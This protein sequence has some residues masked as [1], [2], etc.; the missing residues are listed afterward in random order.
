MK[1]GSASHNII[2]V[3]IRDGIWAF[4]VIL[5]EQPFYSAANETAEDAGSA[6]LLIATMASSMQPPSL[7]RVAALYRYEVQDIHWTTC[8]TDVHVP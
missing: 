3:I 8:L 2:D 1:S 7:E 4:V 5:G 6:V